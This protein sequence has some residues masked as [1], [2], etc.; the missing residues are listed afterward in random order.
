[1]FSEQA[2]RGEMYL[3]SLVPG[4]LFTR[5][6]N[7]GVKVVFFG[8]YCTVYSKNKQIKVDI[9]WVDSTTIALHRHGGG[10]LKKKRD[11]M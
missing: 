8:I 5:D 6:S 11:S 3:L 10:S 4:I 7:G 2:Y 1:M 9:A